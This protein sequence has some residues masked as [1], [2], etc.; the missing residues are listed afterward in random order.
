MRREVEVLQQLA[1]IAVE[2]P[3][4]KETLAQAATIIRQATGAAEAMVV[5]AEDKEFLACSDT[6]GTPETQFT[7]AALTTIQHHVAQAGG[8]VAF[9]LAGHR[10]E[11]FTSAP[12]GDRCQFLALRIPT[13]ESPSEMCILRGA[14]NRKDRAR[15]SRFMESATPALTIILERFLNADRGRRLAQQLQTLANAAQVLTQSEDVKAALRDLATAVSAATGSDYIVCIDMYDATTRRFFLR[16]LSEQRHTTG[17]WDQVWAASLNP[18]RPDPWN[19]EVMRTRQPRLSPDMQNDPTYPEDVRKYFAR[20]LVRSA[21]DFPLLFQDEFLG[22]MS[23]VSFKPHT[24]PPEEVAFLQGFVSQVAVAL[25]ALQMH[26]EVER[27]AQEIKRSADHYIATTNLTGDIIARLDA[28]GKWTF[29]NDAACQFYGKPREELLGADSRAYVHPEDAE[30]TAQSIRDARTR[31]VLTTG[32]VNRC[33]TPKGIRAVEWNGYALFDEDGRYAGIQITGRDI[34]ER[35]QMEA[36]RERLHAELE[37]RATTDSLSGL[38]NHAQFFQ[39]LAEETERS[40]RYHRGFAVVMMDV[41]NFKLY[42]DSRGHQ[43][44]DEVLRFIAGSIQSTMRGS[45][46]AFRYGGDEFAVILLHADAAKAQA[47]VNRINRRI[48]KTLNRMDDG[49][50]APLALSAGVACFPDDGKTADDLVRVADAALYSAKWAAR[51]RDVAR[52]EHAIESAGPSPKTKEPAKMPPAM[53]NSLMAALRRLGVPD[54]LAD[55]NLRTMA[56]LGTLAEIRDPYVRGHQKR[57]SEWAASLA[58]ELGL[59][60]DRVRA[61]KMAGLLHDLGKVGTSRRILNK[62]GKLTEE[63]FAKVKEHPPL[64]S[65]MMMAEIETLQQLVPLIRH[66][67]ERFDGKGYPDGLAGE[68]IPLEARILAVVDAFDAMTHERAYRQALGVDEAVAELKRGAGD[69]FD[70]AV[71]QAFLAVAKR[72]AEEP[73]PPAEAPEETRLLTLVQ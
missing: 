38:Y 32:F 33:I 12:D 7:L 41:D 57:T 51:A 9:N 28:H 20:V 34:T 50:T 66:H 17:I 29:L 53:I 47:V 63:E 27:Y 1:R 26:E 73:A 58:E 18:D 2:G 19:V 13:S 39:R 11:G 37:V 24:F 22:A 49:A 36:D 44:G 62:P 3:A 45:D 21:A 10:V 48:A 56:A 59:P 70:P 8:L 42:N 14:W 15:I 31:K 4:A 25:K 55:L 6:A 67:H 43:A 71:V 64:G 61:T 72:L 46:L 40:K 54:G 69:Q 60:S 65:I 23:F 30:S 5:Y 35:R 52:Q 16:I 68:D